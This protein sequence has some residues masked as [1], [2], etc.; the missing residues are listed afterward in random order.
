MAASDPTTGVPTPTGT[1]QGAAAFSWD[2]S[3][4]QPSD[5]AFSSVATPTGVL[6]GVAPFSWSSG[7]WQPAGHASP[8]V[9]TPTGT[10]DG[11]AVYTWSGSA[12]TPAGGAPDV[13][14][15][16]GTLQGIAAFIWDGS[17]WQPAGQA[18]PE[19][20]T[21]TGVLAGMAMFNWNGAAWGAAPSL[22]LNFMQPGT[23]D[24]RITF[25][26]G[27][28]A[29]Y[30]DS[31]G[32]LQTAAINAPRW[33]Y[34]PS[35]LVLNGVLIEEARTNGIRNS[36]MAG[37][38]A[39]TPGTM[40]TNWG[41]NLGGLSQQIV[42]TGTEN[43]MS[44]LDIRLF[45]TVSGNVVISTDTST[46]TAALTGQQWSSSYY[47]RVV[48]GSTAGMT[49]QQLFLYEL[50][51]V[52]GLVKADAS[53]ILPLP[54]TA[55]LATQRVVQ[56]ATTSGGAT[57][58]FVQQRIGIDLTASAAVD[59]TLRFGAPQLEQGAFPT[60][61]IPTTSAAVT[62]SAELCTMPTGSWFNASASSLAAE[63]MVAQSPNPSTVNSRSPAGLGA[64]SDTN[65][66]RLWGQL[67]NSANAA[68]STA[69]SGANTNSA[70][71]GAPTANA[72]SKIAGAWNGA[73]AAGALN[74]GAVASQS[75]G[76][77]GGLTTLTFGNT[78]PGST[79]YLNGWV[80][81]LS[82]WPRVLTDAE[83]KS[84]TT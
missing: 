50:T 35:T 43:G 58:A 31:T 54:T 20:P 1:L 83:M 75:I 7:A 15:P 21:P 48:G 19:V 63:F 59:V 73:T 60:S 37:A 39:G 81:R 74:G 2:G 3:V 62:R 33:D 17:A 49:G 23:L 51:S 42:G 10:L 16:T 22:N 24:P 67:S 55:P 46:N 9:P 40:P 29:T 52:G 64:G 78:S 32:T 65:V 4:W 80:R 72:V 82:Y 38:V 27:S 25:T 13:P 26:R 45:G 36:T 34:N 84:V 69:I 12:W 76:M 77:P 28:T 79:N 68:I 41:I 61:Y 70:S 57:V 44:Y 71:L 18:A 53:A 8:G 6:R 11:V 47:C 5:R 14:T 56:Q 30:F 66:I